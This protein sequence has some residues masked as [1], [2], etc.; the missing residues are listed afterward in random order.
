MPVVTGYL[1]NDSLYSVTRVQLL[2]EALDAKGAVVA[3]EVT[4]AAADMPPSTRAYF[5]V[6]A[7]A[8][9]SMTYRV[10]VLVFDRV[11]S[12]GE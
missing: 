9:P 7:P 6:R 2:V 8:S 4:W 12:G 10:R 1:T 5:E 3:Q 11:D